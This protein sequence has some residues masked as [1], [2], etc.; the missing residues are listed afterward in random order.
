MPWLPA[1]CRDHGLPPQTGVTWEDLPLDHNPRASESLF[2]FYTDPYLFSQIYIKLGL[3]SPCLQI[4][5]LRPT[6]MNDPSPWLASVTA[7]TTSQVW[8]LLNN[9]VPPV[10]P[11]QSSP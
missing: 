7:E 1:G 8:R 9:I 10:T 5:S 6:E 11:L 2:S 4:G 3:T